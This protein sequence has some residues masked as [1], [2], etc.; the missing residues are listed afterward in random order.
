MVTGTFERDFDINPF[1]YALGM[2][3]TLRPRNINVN[4]SIIVTIGHRSIL[5]EFKNNYMRIE[6]LDFKIIML[7]GQNLSRDH[8]WIFSGRRIILVLGA[9]YTG[10]PIWTGI[11]I[12]RFIIAC[13]HTA[14]NDVS[15]Y[16]IPISK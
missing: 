9:S 8:Y 5:N 2:S 16:L 14:G 1:S 6:V 12:G 10:P 3:R 4:W 7:I 11:K 15:I 13:Y